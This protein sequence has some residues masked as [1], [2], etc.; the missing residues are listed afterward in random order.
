MKRSTRVALLLFFF[1]LCVGGAI[2][3]T[4]DHAE[5]PAKHVTPTRVLNREPHHRIWLRV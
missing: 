1:S 4:M 5:R 3:T 2:L